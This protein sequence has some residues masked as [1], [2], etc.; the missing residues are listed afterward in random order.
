MKKK[1]IN[2]VILTFG[3]I[4]FQFFHFGCKDHTI[5]CKDYLGKYKLD[6]I[7][8]YTYFKAGSSWIYENDS[9]GELDSQILSKIDTFWEVHDYLQYQRIEF[10]ISSISF[11]NSFY[12][13]Q[14]RP[15]GKECDY[16]YSWWLIKL[17]LG[18]D[19]SILQEGDDIVIYAPFVKEKRIG[20]NSFCSY[21]NTIDY[22]K[23]NNDTFKDVIVFNFPTHKG[24]Q[25]PKLL[26]VD[27]RAG[28]TI[29]WAKNVGIIKQ[30][31][32]TYSYTHKKHIVFS[33]NLMKYN[34]LK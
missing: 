4:V 22:Y 1:Q 33:W 31:I 14:Q 17:K 7:L 18:S 28:V 34:I 11:N 8:N 20:I 25:F 26:N 29:Y 10:T 5:K 19:S 3:F 24:Y 15:F 21:I 27:G 23:L 32:S 12:Y 30:S 2:I 9:T 13:H 16:N 6:S